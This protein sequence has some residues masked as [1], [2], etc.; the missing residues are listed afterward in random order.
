ML[1]DILHDYCCVGS[2]DHHYYR[3]TTDYWRSSHRI[4]FELK[5]SSTIVRS[6]SSRDVFAWKRSERTANAGQLISYNSLDFRRSRFAIV[7][8]NV[9]IESP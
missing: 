9:K 5:L 3:I 1:V 7:R 8:L 6:S 4:A 2:L